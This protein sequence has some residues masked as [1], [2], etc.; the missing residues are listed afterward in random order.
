M[1][2][3]YA[4]R[5]WEGLALNRLSICLLLLLTPAP[6][7]AV[8]EPIEGQYRFGHE[9]NTFCTG[10]PERCY[11][12]VETAAEVREELKQQVAGLAPYTPVCLRLDAELSDE[13]ADGFG[14]DYDGSVRVLKLIGPC[15]AADPE[16]TL[17]IED[18]N[19]R[20][21]ILD[22]VD[23]SSLSELAVALGF[24]PDAKLAKLPELDFGEKGFVSGN[25][26]CNSI[27][28][29]ARV[30][31]NQLLLAQLASTAMACSGW[32]AELEL[33]LQLLYRNP[34]EITMEGSDLL[35]AA[36]DTELRFRRRD[37]VQ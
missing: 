3:C 18:L 27:Q 4:A 10:E 2:R 16:A 17:G 24:E 23:G 1:A 8:A 21:W 12:L 32:S 14:Q 30:V 37:W 29:H 34:L 26:G 13:K 28:G 25:T 9:V 31:D 6:H 19:H 36:N 35:L 20:R 11:W 5:M 15:G 22:R 33:R 7:A